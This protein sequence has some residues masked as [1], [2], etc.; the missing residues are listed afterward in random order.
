M[1]LK[2]ISLRNIRS[3][4]K[5]ELDFKEGSTMLSGDIGSG[6]TTILLSIEFALFG[7]MK[8]ILSGSALLRHDAKEGSVTLTFISGKDEIRIS[9]SLKRNA[10]NISQESGYIEINGNKTDCTAVELKAR[11]LS[12]LGYPEELLTKSKSLIF[13]YTVYTPQE[14]MKQIIFDGEDERL[15]KLTKIFNIDKYKRVK[16]N[17]EVYAKELRSE[18]KI[19]HS[20]AEEFSLLESQRKKMEIDLE[21]KSLMM[22]SFQKKI[23]TESKK[24]IEN[25]D[26][27]KEIE[28]TL[29]KLNS[30]KQ[31]INI[32]LI[33][34]KNK[35]RNIESAA[36][37]LK[38]LELQKKK[39]SEDLSSDEIKKHREL[40]T[41]LDE[42][43]LYKEKKEENEKRIIE[44]KSKLG[45]IDRKKE[46]SEEIKKNITSLDKCPTCQQEVGK[47]HK[48]HIFEEE[49]KKIKELEEKEV[50]LKELFEKA[51]KNLSI[52]QKKIESLQVEIL[53]VKQQE[54]KLI[55]RKKQEIMLKEIDETLAERSKL[56]IEQEKILLEDI[57]KELELRKKQEDLMIDDKVVKEISDEL[58]IMKNEF[59][60]LKVAEGQTSE[61]IKNITKNL[62]ENAATLEKKKQALEIVK[63][64]KSLEHWLS[65][66]FIN[67]IDV[68]EKNVLASLRL[69]FKSYFEEWFNMLVED[70]S[71]SVT[72]DER[73]SPKITQNGYDTD[74]INLSGGEKT[75]VALAYRLALNKV[76][77]SM[78]STIKTKDLIILDEPTDGF[79]S[80][81]LDRVRDV[82][83]ALNCKQTIIVSHESKMESFVSH[84]IRIRKQ[85][86]ESEVM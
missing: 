72:I 54:Q 13:R 1:Q 78:I 82:L 74:V 83:D 3:Y 46:E 76:I 19:I 4:A 52:I 49:N 22:Q 53:D 40:S 42:L 67:L 85:E 57:E 20:L 36:A 7:L 71:I 75:A 41:I 27:L 15:E 64:K 2:S 23:E 30:L 66:H 5:L 69:E 17:A 14:E 12:I 80:H 84:I 33:E 21:D 73:F 26:K 55:Y 24:I 61:S 10:S 25:E 45:T 58:K 62:D 16:E 11:V 60:K 65:N 59:M 9:R 32:L 63:K 50:K 38:S 29:K 56:K 31:E 70:E 81:Q 51:N 35:K 18:T 86:H 8:G 39:I 28:D 48:D 43:T 79:S 47:S 68:I 44:C 34:Q 6:K 77:N 37:E